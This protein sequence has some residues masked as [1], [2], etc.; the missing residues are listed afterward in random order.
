MGQFMK[1]GHAANTEGVNLAW[2]IQQEDT[3][4]Y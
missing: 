2:L 1:G 4:S 3:T